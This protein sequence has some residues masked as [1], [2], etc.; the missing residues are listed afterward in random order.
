MP[1]IAHIY[2]TDKGAYD[3]TAREWTIQY[4]QG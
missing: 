2:T 4:A 1:E 3:A